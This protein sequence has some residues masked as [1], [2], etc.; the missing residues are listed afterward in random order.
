MPTPTPDTNPTEP[1][2]GPTSVPPPGG[3]GYPYGSQVAPYAPVPGQNTAYDPN[4]M[5]GKPADP[6]LRIGARVTDII[7]ARAIEFIPVFL[8][9]SVF[10]FGQ[11]IFVDVDNPSADFHYPIPNWS[12]IVTLVIVMTVR[13]INEVVMVTAFGG[14]VGKLIFQLRLVDEHTKKMLSFQSACKRFLV[15]YGPLAVGAIMPAFT[16]NEVAFVISFM[17]VLWFIPLLISI[18]K[19]PP[20]R[21]GYHDRFAHSIVVNK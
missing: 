12:V 14:T 21:M 5:A 19:S 2:M 6:W 16:D 13:F 10:T 11:I 3:V 20:K 17:I 7:I 15:L 18:V 1:E 4:R 9:S 8:L